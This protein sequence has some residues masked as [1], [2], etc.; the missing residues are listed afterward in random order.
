ME[1]ERRQSHSDGGKTTAFK[2][3]RLIP[4]HL[5]PDA[6]EIQL[7]TIEDAEALIQNVANWLA[8]GKIGP[9][10]GN[11]LVNAANSLIEA[12]KL[13]EIDQRLKAIETRLPNETRLPRAK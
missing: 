10:V 11:A 2:V 6:P 9:P 13:S 1:A 7:G 12:K 8:R 4:T 5:G 3:R